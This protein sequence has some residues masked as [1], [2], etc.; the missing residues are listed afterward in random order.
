MALHRL[1]INF[2]VKYVFIQQCEFSISFWKTNGLVHSPSCLGVSLRFL[3]VNLII[4][5]LILELEVSFGI[6]I[7][8][9][10]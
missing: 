7:T 10:S 4:C 3:L 8:V 1:Q 9:A 5:K 2:F 6:R